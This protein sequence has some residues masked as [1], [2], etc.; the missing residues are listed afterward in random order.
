ML[1]SLVANLDRLNALAAQ[2]DLALAELVE[3]V[4]PAPVVSLPLTSEPIHDVEG[5]TRLA[6][7][8]S[9]Q[10]DAGRGPEHW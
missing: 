4:A 2:E 10:R 6:A 5:L 1:G 3:A 8:L 7:L 9:E